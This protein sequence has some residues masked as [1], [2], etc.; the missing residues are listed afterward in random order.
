M[1]N[2]SPETT[3][4]TPIPTVE[5]E[6]T[7]EAGRAERVS[8]RPLRVVHYAR[9]AVLID[10]E[11]EPGWL[12]LAAGGKPKGWAVSLAPEDHQRLVVATEAVNARFFIF[13]GRLQGRR[14]M[15]NPAALV[16]AMQRH[17]SP[18]RAT[19]PTLPPPPA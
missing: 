6:L 18:S 16:D 2:T 9:A 4:A 17:A 7:N 11:D 5:L 8:L 3:P 15:R 19:S 14:L 12:E 10:A 13:Y 1:D